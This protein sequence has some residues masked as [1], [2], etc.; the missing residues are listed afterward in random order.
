MTPE[1]KRSKT[2]TRVKHESAVP[3]YEKIDLVAFMAVLS[4]VTGLFLTYMGYRFGFVNVLVGGVALT[5]FSVGCYLGG[6]IES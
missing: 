1:T 2:G 5:L 3:W 6:L 4:I